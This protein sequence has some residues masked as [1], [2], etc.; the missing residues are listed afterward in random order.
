MKTFRIF[1]LLWILCIIKSQGQGFY[2]LPTQPIDLVTNVALP[3]ADYLADAGQVALST[4]PLYESINFTPLQ[5]KV[6]WCEKRLGITFCGEREKEI[7]FGD[8]ISEEDLPADQKGQLFRNV[9]DI[10]GF[11]KNYSGQHVQFPGKALTSVVVD[12]YFD[13][14]VV[15]REGSA[16]I[17]VPGE[18]EANQLDNPIAIHKIGDCLYVLDEGYPDGRP[19]RKASVAVFQIVQPPD[20]V[21]QVLY[22]G[23]IELTQ[24]LGVSDGEYTDLTGYELTTKNN[25]IVVGTTG[26]HVIALDQNT[27]LANS[28]IPVK[29]FH[30]FILK[31]RYYIPTYCMLLL[32]SS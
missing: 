22:I 15:F 11:A 5:I 28:G 4:D 7:Q 14:L 16:P 19:V 17:I 29:T 10:T 9:T 23:K 18:G 24:V 3:S 26:L 12:S 1:P 21:A 20:E 2:K 30:H 32:P 25:L 6:K 31:P 13:H 8:V 27:G